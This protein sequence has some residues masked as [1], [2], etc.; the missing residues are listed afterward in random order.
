M[1]FPSASELHQ[2]GMDLTRDNPLHPA[3]A[4]A[5]KILVCG[6]D[7]VCEGKLSKL[8]I[9]FGGSHIVIDSPTWQ[10]ECTSGQTAYYILV[11]FMSTL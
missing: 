5:R 2:I 1:G 8:L 9:V 4:K 3:H 7:E 11:G 10:Q 6:R